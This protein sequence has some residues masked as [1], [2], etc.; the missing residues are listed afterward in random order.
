M[1]R[2]KVDKPDLSEKGGLKDGQPQSSDTRLFMQLLAFSGCGDT[3][4]LIKPLADSGIAA[5][6]YENVNDPHGV[7]LLTFST[8]PTHFVTSVRKLIQQ[9][10]FHALT[11]QPEMTM[12]GRTYSL[13]YEPDLNETLLA[14]PRRTALS[15]AW[16]WAVWYPLRRSGLFLQLAPEHQKEILREHG[17]IGMSFGAADFAHDIRL[18]CHGLDKNDNDFVIGLTGKELFPLS[19]IVQTMRKTT[20]TSQYIT[21]LGPFFVGHA[22]WKSPL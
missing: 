18:A 2:P 21:S 13:G 5:V 14:R 12:F 1:E 11:L 19:A 16:N 17:V 8:D 3:Q 6:L 4:S 22:V 20:Q 15:P 10:P 7:A 9:S